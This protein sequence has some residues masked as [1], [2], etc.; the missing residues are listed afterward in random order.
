[1]INICGTQHTFAIWITLNTYSSGTPSIHRQGSS[2]TIWSNLGISGTWWRN[3]HTAFCNRIDVAEKPID[4]CRETDEVRAITINDP[5]MTSVPEIA[6]EELS[7][8]ELGHMQA[9]DNNLATD[10]KKSGNLYEEL[11]PGTTRVPNVQ[12]W[13]IA[14]CP[15][16]IRHDWGHQRVTVWF[17]KCQTLAA[18][19]RYGKYCVL[20]PHVRGNRKREIA[21]ASVT[22]NDAL[23]SLC[24]T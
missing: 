17:Q 16:G 13:G 1:M 24:W 5:D 4:A 23:S 14:S 12:C 7:N 8:S 11:M 19:P 20:I 15:Q 6:S 18:V 9:T 3:Y 21:P 2:M 22:G 10:L